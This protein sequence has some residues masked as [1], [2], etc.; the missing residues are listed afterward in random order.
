MVVYLQK[1][2]L[3]PSYNTYLSQR[4]ETDIHVN[5]LKVQNLSLEVSAPH[6]LV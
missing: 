5:I 3:L 2:E 1:T 6:I 4:L